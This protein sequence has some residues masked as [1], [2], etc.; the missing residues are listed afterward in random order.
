MS[1]RRHRTVAFDLA[2][3]ARQEMANDMLAARG[4]ALA[5]RARAA[6]ERV[7]SFASNTTKQVLVY[8]SNGNSALGAVDPADIEPVQSVT[9]PSQINSSQSAGPVAAYTADGDL[10]GFVDVAD[11]TEIPDVQDDDDDS[12]LTVAVAG[13][14][15][16]PVAPSA[17]PSLNAGGKNA[18]CHEC[19]KPR[20]NSFRSRPVSPTIQ[21]AAGVLARMTA[22]EREELKLATRNLIHF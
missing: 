22:E 14:L 13:P 20:G 21:A 4:A 16:A 6:Q 11:L 19:S 5:E 12:T 15:T 18:G 7:A 2:S 1:I 8:G 3:R 9:D 17:T 10:V